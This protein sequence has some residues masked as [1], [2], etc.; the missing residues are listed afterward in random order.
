M[1]GSGRIMKSRFDAPTPGGE[2]E[3]AAV[4]D[5]DRRKFRRIPARLIAHF[6]K[7]KEVKESGQTK[8]ISLGGVFI[9]THMTFQI[10][11]AVS[12]DLRLPVEKRDASAKVSIDGVVRWVRKD[13]GGVG[14]EIQRM[15]V[16]DR[17]R[18]NSYIRELPGG[19]G[20]K[21][22]PSGVTRR[23]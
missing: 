2:K 1:K 3:T 5:E 15:A 22:Q 21:R 4:A 20:K 13:P 16:S 19:N 6:R 10:G 23:K 18:M 8:N 12:F 7:G 11:D 17:R 9:E 14:V